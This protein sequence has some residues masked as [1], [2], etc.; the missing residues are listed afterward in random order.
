MKIPKPCRD[1]TEEARGTKP[2][3]KGDNSMKNSTVVL[4]LR[5]FELRRTRKKDHG[6]LKAKCDQTVGSGSRS[7]WVYRSP[8]IQAGFS[9]V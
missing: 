1:A 6:D 9:N 5:T 3:S 8:A 2:S 4:L 7:L